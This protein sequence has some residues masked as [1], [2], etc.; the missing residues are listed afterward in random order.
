MADPLGIVG[1]IGAATSLIEG[2]VRIGI[3]WKEAPKDLQMFIGELQALKTVLSETSMNAN[4]SKDFRDAFEGRRSR[5]LRNG[6]LDG[7]KSVNL[8]ALTASCTTELQ[9]L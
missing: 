5:L 6:R 7:P 9:Q 1:L 4:L 8:G 2:G 3:N